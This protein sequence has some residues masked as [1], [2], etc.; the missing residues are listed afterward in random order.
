MEKLKRV[1]RSW[2][3]K[4]E[5]EQFMEHTDYYSYVN[6]ASM[7]DYRAKVRV[8]ARVEFVIEID[9]DEDKRLIREM[10]HK[11]LEAVADKGLDIN[12]FAYVINQGYVMLPA[13]LRH[14]DPDIAK[15]AWI[16]SKYMAQRK[17]IVHDKI[18]EE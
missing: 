6:P 15:I 11:G 13:L 17:D 18:I 2:V 14:S 7:E 12:K 10:E 4:V 1:P 16:I 3:S 8:R 5:F 9:T